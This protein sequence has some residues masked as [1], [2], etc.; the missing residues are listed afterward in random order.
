MVFVYQRHSYF[1]QYI[2]LGTN[3]YSARENF[4]PYPRIS[5]E[6]FHFTLCLKI[7]NGLNMW[8]LPHIGQKGHQSLVAGVVIH[9]EMQP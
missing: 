4:L 3:K 8:N 9:N 6:S 2:F 7:S 5:I 1:S